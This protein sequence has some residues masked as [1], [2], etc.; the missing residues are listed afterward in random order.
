MPKEVPIVHT[1]SAQEPSWAIVFE[2]NR[3]ML[4]R[5]DV[6]ETGEIHPVVCGIL[7]CTYCGAKLEKPEF[8]APQNPPVMHYPV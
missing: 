4:A 7:F 6:Q 3:W 1:C 8:S 5:V 2:D